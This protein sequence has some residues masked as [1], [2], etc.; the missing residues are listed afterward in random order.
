MFY[1]LY[2]IQ[3][4]VVY[5]LH[6]TATNSEWRSEK[7]GEAASEGEAARPR[8]AEAR[9]GSQGLVGHGCGWCEILIA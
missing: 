2:F 5:I 7:G 9:R 3:M 1:Y 4:L 6:F 8:S